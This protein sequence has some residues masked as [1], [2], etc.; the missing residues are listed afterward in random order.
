ME[1]D[2]LNAFFEFCGAIFIGM[3][4]WKI[5]YD[6]EVKGI[7]WLQVAFFNFWGVWN[8]FYYPHLD[9]WWSFTAGI[10]L[11]SSNTIYLSLLIWFSRYPQHRKPDD[12]DDVEPYE[13]V[14]PIEK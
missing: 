8:L 7:S 3:S 6:K 10:L 9:Q 13:V 1:P 12:L 5:W 11:T 2:H 14:H 4:I